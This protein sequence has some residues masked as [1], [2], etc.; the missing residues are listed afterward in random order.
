MQAPPRISSTIN[1]GFNSDDSN[2]SY[3]EKNRKNGV[4]QPSSVL[5]NG[6]AFYRPLRQRE[7]TDDAVMSDGTNVPNPNA[8]VQDVITAA[9][10]V[11]ETKLPTDIGQ[12]QLRAYRIPDSPDNHNPNSNGSGKRNY[13]GT[14]ASIAQQ[15]PC[16]I[17]SR[18]KPPFGNATHYAQNVPVRIHD[19]CLTSEVFGSQ[20]YE[21]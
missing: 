18:D 6:A 19:Q 16:V 12:F 14:T 21:I 13:P 4:E 7:R 5:P 3:N 8:S 17:Y 2:N 1:G 9:V 10:H 15:E 11:A 20:R